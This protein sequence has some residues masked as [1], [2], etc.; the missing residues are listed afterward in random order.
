MA[1]PHPTLAEQLKAARRADGA[2]DLGSLIEAVSA[3][4]TDFER[5]RD[6]D[7]DRGRQMSEALEDTVSSHEELLRSMQE[8]N[9]RFAAA[10]EN[11][12]QGLCMFNPE[13]RMVVC[14]AR[15]L[16]I[17]GIPEHLSPLGISLTRLLEH[18]LPR[19]ADPLDAQKRIDEYLQVARAGTTGSFLLELADGRWLSV[20][21]EPM[22]NGG[23][24][25]TFEDVTAR[26]L[27]DERIAHLATHDV[28]T[29]LANR[30]L[31][32][33]HI[34]SLL[35]ADAGC[36]VLCLD[37]DRFKPVND[38]LGH[39]V[40]DV[41][42]QQVAERLRQKVRCQDLVARLG[43]DE[44][45]IVLADVGSVRA[46]EIA[47]RVVKALGEAF[48]VGDQ[49]IVIGASVGIAIGPRDGRD[50]PELLKHADL[51]LYSAK[52]SGRNCHRLFE[53]S[54][55]AVAQAR[56]ELEV[57]L[58]QA[59][60]DEQF[61]VHYQPLVN[62]ATREVEGFEALLR[63]HSPNRGMVSPV[64]FIPLAE[65]LELIATLGAWVLRRACA[66]AATWPD[67]I[68]LAVN[69]SPKQF[70]GGALLPNVLQ[71]LEESHLTPG[72]LELEI[73]E[74]VLMDRQTDT[75]H[76]L[77][78]LREIGVGITMDD[79]GTGYSSLAYL[80]SF[81]FDK[82]KID[83]SFVS[84]LGERA[85]AIAIVRAVTGLCRSLGITST[86][87]GVETRSQLQMLMHEDCTQIQGYLFSR[88]IPA[89]AV[90]ALI[91]NLQEGLVPPD[92][93]EPAPQ[94]SA[95]LSD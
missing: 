50:A 59:I 33:Q 57:D 11:M 29:D 16:A 74:S 20:A 49:K 88:P 34:A 54:M 9:T 70:Q 76:T 69:V 52:I 1:T 89:H 55:D 72:R 95:V 36:A 67:P 3:T 45:A 79:F 92:A 8:Q 42:L 60:A 46:E 24:V 27:A 87:E 17:W 30:S 86:A 38:S 31:L 65:E 13:Q 37:L 4:Y 41:V 94:T 56:R 66:D 81:P 15:F 22:P 12:S 25:Q 19:I 35:A 68:K 32:E 39:P 93:L 48:E 43:G 58:R 10:L 91:E 71:A 82:I 83:R 2:T 75:M 14:N 64:V 63:W 80:S 53:P 40:G 44:F 47:G 18:A 21:H 77:H 78:R 73:T 62:T 28:L 85:D 5:E 61:Q 84:A 51:A 23:F 90:P 7:R 6:R 26:R